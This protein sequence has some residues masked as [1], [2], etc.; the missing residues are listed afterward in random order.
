MQSGVSSVLQTDPSG[1]A[2]LHEKKLR[3]SCREF[4][5]M[6]VSMMIKSM[7]QA[8][9][10]DDEPSFASGVYQDMFY[11]KVSKVIAQSGRLGVGDMLYAQLD[12]L[13]K[14]HPSA[15][16]LDAASAEAKK[17]DLSPID[18][19]TIGNPSE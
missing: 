3:D 9:S 12:R 1:K 6:L 14:A 7:R 13:E 16:A 19:S 11:D 18:L 8:Y 5:S 15:G 10:G 4:S 2:E 17:A